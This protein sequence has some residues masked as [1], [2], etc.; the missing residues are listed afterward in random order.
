MQLAGGES[1]INHFVEYL[2]RRNIFFQRRHEIEQRQIEPVARDVCPFAVIRLPDT[3]HVFRRRR[4]NEPGEHGP[5]WGALNQS[6]HAGEH[7]W[8]PWC[9]QGPPGANSRCMSMHR[10]AARSSSRTFNSPIRRQLPVPCPSATRREGYAYET[11]RDKPAPSPHR[12]K[13]ARSPS[14]PERRRIWHVQH[15]AHAQHQVVRSNVVEHER[16]VSWQLRSI[17]SVRRA[18]R[19]IAEIGITIHQFQGHGGRHAI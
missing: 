15:P 8:Q 17:E 18:R 16:A 3:R 5:R 13:P 19:R 11:A 14:A 6:D 9:F 4:G 7:A 2:R 10:C 1:R 12:A